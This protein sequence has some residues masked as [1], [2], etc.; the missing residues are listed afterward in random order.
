MNA[1]CVL[2]WLCCWLLLTDS[3]RRSS[4]TDP[5]MPWPAGHTRY[6]GSGGDC[7]VGSV[8]GFAVG[9]TGLHV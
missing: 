7:D 3:W 2:S 4:L 1:T 9:P 6:L 5:G 8:L